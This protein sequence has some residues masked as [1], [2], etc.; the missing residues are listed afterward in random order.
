M[1]DETGTNFRVDVSSRLSE[2]D[3]WCPFLQWS[4]LSG[5]RSVP[6]MSNAHIDRARGED[7]AGV[8][9]V[10]EGAVALCHNTRPIN[11]HAPGH[12]RRG[13]SPRR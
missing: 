2:A 4:M 7:E 10:H 11:R 13:E 3:R 12:A 5:T 9:G 6:S 1:T 8:G